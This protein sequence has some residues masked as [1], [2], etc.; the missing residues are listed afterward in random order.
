MTHL[1]SDPII[2][3]TSSND[4]LINNCSI[5]PDSFNFVKAT[6]PTVKAVSSPRFPEPPCLGNSDIE[7]EV[8]LSSIEHDQHLPENHC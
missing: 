8:S 3:E 6:L 1:P 2:L 7:F 4:I 5:S